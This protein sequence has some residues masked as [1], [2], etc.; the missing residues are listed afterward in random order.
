M[1]VLEILKPLIE[2]AAARKVKVV[3]MTA[4]GV[5]ADDNIPYREAE[6]LL[7]KSGTPY[8]IVRPNW[9]TDNFVTY[10]GEGI[11]HGVIAVPAGE[12]KSS[13]IDT[14]DIADSVVAALTS[15]A[16]DGKAFDLTGPEALGYAEAAALIG[17]ATGKEVAY[18]ALTDDAFVSQLVGFGVPEAYAKFLA[19]IFYPVR[20]GWTAGVT[21]SVE[22][23]TGNP[24]RT[25]AAWVAENAGT[26]K[27]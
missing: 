8:V 17:K 23:L 10:W 13:F 12:G 16:F 11:K 2:L 21:N 4:L 6:I 3:L 14:R 1:T 20:E 9:F 19:S 7:E 22:T 24:P 18:V 27:G 26:L 5:N 15:S 25:V